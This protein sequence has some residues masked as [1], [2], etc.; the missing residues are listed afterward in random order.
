MVREV[1]D[2]KMRIAEHML[3]RGLRKTAASMED[4]RSW[5]PRTRRTAKPGPRTVQ[6]QT[7][8]RCN[9][10]CTMCPYT[11]AANP[12][13]TNIM[14]D[15]LYRRII[16]Q[17]S[18]AGT[19]DNIVLMLQNEPLLDRGFADRIRFAKDAFDGRVR[20]TTKTNGSPLTASL[21]DQLA[22]SGIDRVSVSIDAASVE[23]YRRIRHG[24]DYHRVLA[25]TVSLIERMGPR[26][27]GVSFVRQRD[28]QGE[29]RAFARFWHRRGVEVTFGVLTNRAGSLDSFARVK[30]RRPP[31]WRRLVNPVLNRCVP[32]CPLPF[33]TM[34]VLWDGR[35]VLCCHDWGPRDTL[36]DLSTQTLADVWNGE[37]INHYRYLLQTHRAGESRVCAD[38][39]Q[40]DRFWTE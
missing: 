18:K 21:I 37:R 4:F 33:R 36:G 40:A 5:D 28:N 2:E 7:V 35:A 12:A 26:R 1:S 17:L 31:L 15:G 24:L 6:I 23:A 38:C 8:D 34:N 27:V 11:K 10:H 13:P 19:V 32:V 9:A 30:R 3:A 39:S 16:G 29:D 14:D 20:I 22:A 25:N